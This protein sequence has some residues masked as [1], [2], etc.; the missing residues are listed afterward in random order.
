MAVVVGMKIEADA[1]R[2]GTKNSTGW[3]A[4]VYDDIG[5]VP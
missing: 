3:D 2:K 1:W 5:E 4:A